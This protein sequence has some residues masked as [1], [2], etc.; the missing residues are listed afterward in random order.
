MVAWHEH[1]GSYRIAKNEKDRYEK[2]YHRVQWTKH[3]I[4]INMSNAECIP[5][6]KAAP[7]K[8][9][10]M[11][12]VISINYGSLG[13]ALWNEWIGIRDRYLQQNLGLN[14]TPQRRALKDTLGHLLGIERHAE[15]GTS[16]RG[17]WRCGKYNC[18]NI[19]DVIID[20]L[21]ICIFFVL[22]W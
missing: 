10:K 2:E 5:A 18:I 13:N 3:R 6:P 20:N 4:N 1:C 9:R 8:G 12:K 15:K 21:Y 11:G 19:A 14:V 16:S 22:C 7:A 17:V